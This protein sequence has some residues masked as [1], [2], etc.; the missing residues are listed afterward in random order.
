MT[1]INDI[2]TDERGSVYAETATWCN[3]NNACLKEI[4]PAGKFRRFKIV[5]VP[6]PDEN[7]KKAFIRSVRNGYLADTDKYMIADFPITE[8]MRAKYQAYRQ[9]LRDYTEMAEW[10]E[11]EPATFGEWSP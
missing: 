3:R 2:I 11:K 7:E 9:Y 5:T 10:F 8:E 6:E 4:E 1:Q